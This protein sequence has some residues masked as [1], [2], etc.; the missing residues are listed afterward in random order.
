MTI[1][2]L[3][4]R[5]LVCIAVLGAATCSA[6]VQAANESSEFNGV[7][8]VAKPISQL[9]AADG[10]APPLLPEAQ[11]LYRQRLTQ[12]KSGDRSYDDTLKCKPMGEPRTAYDPEGGPFEILVNPKVVLFTYTWNRMVRFVYVNDRPVD[13][14]GPTFYG[15]AN[16][17]WKGQSLVIDSQGF[18]DQTLLDAAGLPHSED[19]H[20]TETYTL[21]NQGKI[22][23]ERIRFEDPKTFTKPWEATIT[24]RRL[25]DARIAEQVCD[26]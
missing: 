9:K 16:A 21:K 4:R 11:K 13:V 23:E 10:S 8:R 6:T 25:P 15:T 12:L 19:L 2:A 24:Y 14:I 5:K 22:L 18:H 26:S 3:F 1:S 20:L 7:W 17:Q